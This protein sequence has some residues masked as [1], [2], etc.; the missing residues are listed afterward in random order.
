[1]KTLYIVAILLA[2]MLIPLAAAEDAE[3]ADAYIVTPA[4]E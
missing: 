4:F 1:M 3:T 2:A